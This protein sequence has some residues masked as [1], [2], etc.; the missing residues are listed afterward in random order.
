MLRHGEISN[1]TLSS[2][3]HRNKNEIKKSISWESW[4]PLCFITYSKLHNNPSINKNFRTSKF[5]PKVS[6]QKFFKVYKHTK[7]Q[8]LE[9]VKWNSKMHPL[10]I[11]K[12]LLIYHLKQ[13]SRKFMHTWRSFRTSKFT[14]M[15]SGLKFIQV[16]KHTK[17]Q[18][19]EKI[20]WNSKI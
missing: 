16:Y 17:I 12:T 14:L 15:L 3:K 4:K 10:I 5:T 9:Q 7:I 19:L 1:Y 20:I 2:F 8:F 6:G 13:T 18:F 11:I